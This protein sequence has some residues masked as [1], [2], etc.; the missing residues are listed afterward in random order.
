MV[1]KTYPADPAGSDAGSPRAVV[2][3]DIGAPDVIAWG[4]SFR[5]LAI[6]AA[7]GGGVWAAHQRFGSLLPPAGWVAAAIGVVAVSV[8]LALG[9]RDGLPLD[10]W[11]RHGLA[12]RVTAPV[13]APT[14]PPASRR[15]GGGGAL[16]VTSSR[17][18]TPAPLR[19]RATRIDPDGTV[20]VD[21][22]PRTVIAC[23][24][25]SV[26]LRTG[27]EQAGVLAGFGRWLNSLTGPTQIVVSAARL[28][29][30]AHAEAVLEV[31]TRLPDPTLRRAAADHAGFLVDLDQ[32][33]EPLRRQV[34]TVVAAGPGGQA[35]VRAL[36]ALGIAAQ[37]LDGPATA[38][39]LAAAVDPYAPPVPGPRAP[40]GIPVT[41]RPD[42]SPASDN[43]PGSA[44]QSS[45][46]RSSD[47][48]GGP[49][50]GVGVLAGIDPG[51]ARWLR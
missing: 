43:A 21:G 18:V 19:A 51:L 16:V 22:T 5:Q 46:P 12:L 30:T 27:A 35:G 29:L 20:T 44:A 8:T 40:L 23:G 42:P 11:L 17:P 4:L 34:L 38:A 26:G 1:N 50:T 28:D 39:A 13:L 41:A 33:R 6:I 47:P 9:R 14:D 2:S 48:P 3:A 36:T 45:S 49:P 25:T 15:R 24:T 7:G 31:A 37:V 32:T 10:V